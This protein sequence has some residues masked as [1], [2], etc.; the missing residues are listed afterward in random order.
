MYRDDLWAAGTLPRWDLSTLQN[1]IDAPFAPEC[2]D[3]S[4]TRSQLGSQMQKSAFSSVLAQLRDADAEL[5]RAVAAAQGA[6][7]VV[8]VIAIPIRVSKVDF[9][10]GGLSSART[11]K[12]VYVT[13]GNMPP[14][15]E[16]SPSSVEPFSFMAR[17]PF[18]QV[19][20]T[21]A[22]AGVVEFRQEADQK[23]LQAAFF[24]EAARIARRG[25]FVLGARPP[26]LAALADGEPPELLVAAMYLESMVF[27]HEAMWKFMNMLYFTPPKYS[28]VSGALL[29]CDACAA[30]FFAA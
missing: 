28:R 11:V 9:G 29:G 26:G 13:L 19:S 14:P 24:D 17:H 12:P 25:A 10:A 2:Q 30:P 20:G 21:T 8:A 6:G 27:D 4:F 5:A 7:K 16:H 1:Y 23:Q 18:K 15:V 3:G 22:G